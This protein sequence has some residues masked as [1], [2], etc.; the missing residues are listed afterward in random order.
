MSRT[1]DGHLHISGDMAESDCLLDLLEQGGLGGI[2]IASMPKGIGYDFHHSNERA[3]QIKREYPGRIFVFGGLDYTL[4][5]SRDGK[6]DFATQAARL[7][8]AGAD[9]IKMIEGKPDA[10]KNLGIPLDSPIF[11]SFHAFME[12]TSRPILLHVGDPKSFWDKASIPEWA[13]KAGW[14]WGNGDYPFREQLYAELEG[15]LR[16]HPRLKVILAHL[17]VKW[18]G[19]AD[20]GDMFERWDHVYADLTP[21]T[22]MYYGF[23]ADPGRWRPLFEKYPDRLIFGTDN[24]GTYQTN[25]TAHLQAS[26]TR[27]NNVRRCLETDE[28]VFGGRG[29]KLDPGILRKLYRDNFIKA[30]T[31]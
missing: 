11:D 22:P 27:L 24:V 13:M 12:E 20:I 9:G 8:A 31:P 30:I 29:L 5:G 15:L 7:F 2:N 17:G 4:P 6:V 23:A 16:K 3:L 25:K 21:G 1:I 26:L 19:P 28:P 18:D 14:Y 10:R